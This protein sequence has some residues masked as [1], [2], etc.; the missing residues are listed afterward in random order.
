MIIKDHISKWLQ[1]AQ[2]ISL[3][4]YNIA[5]LIIHQGKE[6]YYAIISWWI[7]ENMLQLFAYFSS[8]PMTEDFQMVSDK[9]IVSC[10]WEMAILWFERNVWVEEVM[11]QHNN[12]DARTNYLNRHLNTII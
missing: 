10:V 2:L 8:N 1:H 11:L 9:G 4:H 7:D 6:G 12:P 5:T 3:T